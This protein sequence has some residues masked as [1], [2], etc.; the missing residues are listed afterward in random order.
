M[1]LC[2]FVGDSDVVSSGADHAADLGD[3][4]ACWAVALRQAQSR[5]DRLGVLVGVH[6]S[7][8]SLSS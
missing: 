5:M 4:V 8:V 3:Q 7:L 1:F 2:F 6:N